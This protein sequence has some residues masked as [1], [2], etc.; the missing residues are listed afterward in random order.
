MRLLL[1]NILTK[2]VTKIRGENWI[3][4]PNI[5]FRYLIN[6]IFSKL[7]MSLRGFFTKPTKFLKLFVGKNVTI[8]GKKYIRIKNFLLI[9]D[10]SY[11]DALSTD[12][13]SFGNNVTLGRN[14]TIICTG[15]LKSIGK[16]FKVGDNVGLGADCFFGCAGGISIGNDTI[17]GN[18]ISLH[19]ENHNYNQTDLP[20]RLQGVNSKGISIGDNC[21]I[22]AKSIILDGAKIGDNTIIAAGSVVIGKKYDSNS[23]YAGNPA[24]FIKKIK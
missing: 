1:I 5:S 15:S 19:S 14:T 13:I 6:L 7:I 17:F 9:G 18:F 11:I 2:L 23:I 21:W 24:K 3:F 12:G 8:K 4:D 16:G 10:N 22:G 20:I